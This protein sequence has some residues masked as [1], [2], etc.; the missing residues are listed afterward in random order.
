VTLAPLHARPFKQVD[1]FTAV[2]YLGNPVAVVLDATGLSTEQ[3]QGMARWTNLSETTFVLPPTLAQAD[4]RV[5][6]FTPGSELPF[7]GHPTIGTAHALLEAGL[8]Q[9]KDGALIQECQVGPVRLT[10]GANSKGQR[11]IGFELPAAT[12]TDMTPAQTGRLLALFPTMDTGDHRPRLVDVGPRWIMVQMPDSQ[13]VLSA[14]PDMAVISALSA[15]ARATGVV[16]FGACDG[17]SETRIEVRAFAPL[18]G[19]QEDPVC[20]SGNG[21]MAA[22]IRE[23]GQTGRFGERFTA[24]QGQ[25]VGRSGFIQIGIT[26]KSIVVG[27]CAVTCIDGLIK[28]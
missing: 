2:P 6:I 10:V 15:D 28:A 8:I 23:T 12:F 22:F 4:Y 5:R 14:R 11:T 7:A 27:G 1:V 25:V 18:C 16:L 24:S 3:M 13:A 21:C 26:P 9:P 19:I 17:Q 20:G